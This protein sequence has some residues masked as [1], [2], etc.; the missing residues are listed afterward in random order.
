MAFAG[1]LA[2]ALLGEEF[3]ARATAVVLGVTVIPDLDAFVSLV[4]TVGHRTALHTLVLPG[5]VALALLADTRWRERSDL[6]ERYGDRGLRVAWMSVLALAVAGIGLDLV[7]GGANPLWPIHDQFYRVSGK[8][9]LS[10]Q[11]GLVQTFLDLDGGS[12]SPQSLGS[13]EEVFVST[14][15]DP[16]PGSESKTVDRVFP[17]VRSGWQLLVL[18][19]GT[20]VT[21]AKVWQVENAE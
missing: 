15:V 13:S 7:T 19:V 11:R 16:Q 20:I 3:D 8:V 6:L 10:T 14:G 2:A 12:P 5:L 9:E 17:V 21:A 4:S 18:V 1:L